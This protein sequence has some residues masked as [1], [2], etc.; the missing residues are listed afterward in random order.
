[1]DGRVTGPCQSSGHTEDETNQS[2]TEK[3]IAY[4]TSYRLFH[5]MHMPGQKLTYKL[6]I[7]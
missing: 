1:M 6:L 5:W 3:S 7:M 4:N 2:K